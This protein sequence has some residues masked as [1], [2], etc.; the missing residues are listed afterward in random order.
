MC[1]Q[2]H[3]TKTPYDCGYA[4]AYYRWRIANVPHKYEANERIED[5]TP[6]EVQSYRR[7]YNAQDDRK[8][9]GAD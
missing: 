5:L 9:Y 7:G 6:A 2:G 1:Q 3:G 4:D 8:E